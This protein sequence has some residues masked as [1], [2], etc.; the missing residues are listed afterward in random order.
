[1]E[2]RLDTWIHAHTYNIIFNSQI[3][4]SLEDVFVPQQGNFK[5]SPHFD[6]NLLQEELSSAIRNS[7]VSEK[8]VDILISKNQALQILYLK[9]YVYKT[10]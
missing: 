8:Q 6:Q 10:T 2:N 7:Y 9:H 1:M 4:S 3:F 5:L